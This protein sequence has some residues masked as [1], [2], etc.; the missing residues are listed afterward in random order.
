MTR[1]IAALYR[2]FYDGVLCRLPETAALSL[3]QM[4]IAGI[5]RPRTKQANAPMTPRPTRRS[6]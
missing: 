1:A 5:G 6:L 3:G 4:A 2:A